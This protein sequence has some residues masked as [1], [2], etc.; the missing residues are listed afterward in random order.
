MIKR[1]MCYILGHRWEAAVSYTEEAK[2]KKIKALEDM[3]IFGTGEYKTESNDIKKIEIKCT[4]CGKT[5]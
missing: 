5:K 2:R 3:L 4:R 1:F